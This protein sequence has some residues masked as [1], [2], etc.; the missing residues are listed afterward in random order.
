MLRP[1]TNRKAIF[2][3]SLALAALYFFRVVSEPSDHESPLFFSSTSRSNVVDLFDFE[4]ADSEAI[5]KVCQRTKWNENLIFTCDKSGGGVG[6]LRNSVLNCVRYAIHGGGGLVVPRIIQRS[7]ED[8]ALI[9][10][11]ETTEFDY[12]FDRAHFVE[13]LRRSCPQMEVFNSSADIPTKFPLKNVL[14][15]E[16][17]K[18]LVANIPGNG[19]WPTEVWRGLFYKW[20]DGKSS[21]GNGAV[22]PGNSTIDPVVVGLGRSYVSNTQKTFFSSL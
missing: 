13:S 9:W 3:L 6:N 14:S 4:P 7:P 15:L 5:R 19:S 2:L 18:E 10:N 16:P 20:L 21:P 12:I 17:E 11:R 1:L 22:K 8:I